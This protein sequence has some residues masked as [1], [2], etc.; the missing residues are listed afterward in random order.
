MSIQQ[1][2]ASL[3]RSKVAKN[4]K[5]LIAGK[6]VHMILAFLIGLLSARYLGPGNYGLI[7]YAGAYISFFTAIC[8]LGINSIIVRNFVDHPEEE[9]ETIGTAIAL[10]MASSFLS[11]LMI[12]GIVSILNRD[13][14]L[15]I[16]VTAL[17]SIS[18]LFQVFDT[19]NYWFQSR[20]QSKY[21]AMATLISYL[22]ASAYRIVLLACGKDVRW[23]AIANA[24][25]YA[26]AALFLY[27]MYRKCRGPK[28][29]F[30]WRKAS[31]LLRSSRSFII[32]GLMVS[33]YNST[34]RLMLKQMMDEASVGYYSS[35]THICSMWVFILTAIIDS[36]YPSIMQL[37][38][39]DK[40]KYERTNRQL[41][42]IVFY[43][44][45]FASLAISLLASP[46]TLILYGE[47]YLPS[48]APLRIMTWYTAFSYLGV[49]RNAW[50]VCE[51]KQ[52]YLLPLYSGAALTNV[53][54]NYI[55]IPIWGAS[56]AA[57]ASLIT[58]IT[59]IFVFPSLIRELRP[60]AKMMLD[61]V[62]LR[63]ILPEKTKKSETAKK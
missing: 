20:Y 5:W 26:I 51:N 39:T 12:I 50:M 41:Y 23:F 49:A 8:T 33:I 37:Y 57:A 48:A 11:M 45:V 62:L 9:G 43:L 47:A 7:N 22:V 58:Q 19:L 30:S 40:E 6:I 2:V 27:L 4:A 38:N 13:E 56:G 18:L 42:A 21:Y 1:K 61:A 35:A 16:V 24:I 55:M 10:R 29:S 52:K 15:T 34:D 32:A 59:T 54:L 28:F 63:K 36:L 44:S 17:C 14:P 60:N 31:E 46:I 53:V 3:L 25:D